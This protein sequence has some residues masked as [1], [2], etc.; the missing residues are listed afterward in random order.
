MLP[1]AR[2]LQYAGLTLPPLAIV[3][4]LMSSIDVRDMLIMLVAGGA[5]FWLGRLIEG[6]A[7]R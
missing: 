1:L 4:Q 5:A 6:Y 2:L 7:R 3:L